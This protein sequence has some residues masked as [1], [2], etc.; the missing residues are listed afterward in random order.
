[1][2][3]T[4]IKKKSIGSMLAIVL[5]IIAVMI[6]QFAFAITDAE[7]EQIDNLKDQISS[8][9]DQIASSQNKINAIEEKKAQSKQTLSD[10]VDQVDE[11]DRQINNYNKKISI[12]NQTIADL[13]AR[14]KQTQD[15]MATQEQE[16]AKT[17]GI[18]SDRLRAMYMAGETSS[19]E[20][21]MSSDSF[22]NFLTRM[23]LVQG[24]A[25][26]DSNLIKDLQ[27]K[28]N[29]LKQMEQSLH[30][31][32]VQMQAD[33]DSLSSAKAQ[34]LPKKRAIDSKVAEINRQMN[35]LKEAQKDAFDRE[36]DDILNGKVED[37]SGSVGAMIWP[38]PYRGT[39][40]TSPYGY[41]TMNGQTKFHYGVD[42]SMSDKYNKN[43]VA[44]ADGKVVIASND[45]SYNGGYGNYLAI[46]HGNGV[47]TVYGHCASLK[48][49][50]NQRVTQGQPV[51]I[52]G[53]TGNSTGVHVH[54]EVRINGSKKNPLNYVNMPSD[55]YIKK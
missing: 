19:I 43:L 54:F 21:L 25:R 30:D 32:Q 18:L 36:V 22:E 24:V 9:E 33:K 52:M 38:L 28:I 6:P 39:Y 35:S 4:N 10:L 12:L 55:V 48:V 16:I 41:R 5:L 3:R 2:N 40:I 45:G 26:H 51:A 37:G 49:V 20:I 47:V 7:Q 23:E 44:S 14:I 53:T 15:N 34:L 11:L 42:I 50:L 27:D 29:E 8:I 31:Q 17:K 46:D 1:M 13:N